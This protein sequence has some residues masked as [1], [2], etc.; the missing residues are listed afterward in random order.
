MKKSN[1]YATIV[2]TNINVGRSKKTVCTTERIKLPIMA[3][4]ADLLAEAKELKLEVTEKNTIA[5]IEA[6]I[7]GA[8]KPTDKPE[9]TKT[10]SLTAKLLLPNQASVAKK[11]S[12]KPRKRPTRKLAKKQATPHLRTR[13]LKFTP[14]RDQS[15]SLDQRLS[16]VARSIAS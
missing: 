11:Q 2:G 10:S 12:M 7:A 15:Q 4:K 8:A 13:T 6:A 5:E 14:K 1:K 3:K 16:A 9:E